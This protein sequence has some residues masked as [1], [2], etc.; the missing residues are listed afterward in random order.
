MEEKE[1]HSVFW[2]EY[3]KQKLGG[4]VILMKNLDIDWL[5]GNTEIIVHPLQPYSDLVVY[6]L[7]ELS[8]ILRKQ[9]IQ[10]KLP[11][12]QSLAF[13]CRK[14]HILKLKEKANNHNSLGR[15]LV[16]HITPSNVPVNFAF[17]FFFGLLSGNANI[18]RVPSK[19]F[20]Q[21]NLICH[22]VKMLFEKPEYM[23]LKESNALIRYGHNQ[24]ITDSLSK[25]ADMRVIWGGDGTIAQI[26]KSPLKAKA[27]EI[28]FADRFSLGILDSDAV[29]RTSEA[30]C[31]QLARYF[32]ND[33]YLMDQNACSTPHLLLW[34]GKEKEAAQ[35][36]FWKAVF[37]EAQ[38]YNLEP[39]KVVDKY[40]DLCIAVMKNS[41]GI[42]KITQWENLLYTI[43]MDMLPED[44]CTL[45]G[46]FGMFYQYALKNLQELAPFI[47]ERVQ[48]LLYYG[49][50]AQELMNFVLNNHLQ[51]I[52]RIVPFGNSLDMDVFWD[53][54][55]IVGQLSRNICFK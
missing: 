24:E 12:V 7:D 43:D 45:R 13:W 5:A 11:D 25:K 9:A 48:T 30:E 38:K 51:G 22:A 19:D 21:V 4:A 6:F 39:I 2:E 54:Y 15:G 23:T 53:G 41:S 1:K 8:G 27:G 50:D 49:L 35:E 16:F 46:R 17:S 18:V 42:K 34:L 47:Q 3:R 36:K 14:S 40:T 31:T 26:R 29:L 44:I 55:D 10:E 52:D 20:H 37:L 33:T 28:V 32:Y